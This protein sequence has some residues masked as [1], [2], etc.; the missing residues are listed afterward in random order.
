MASKKKELKY[1]KEKAKRWGSTDYLL[2]KFDD[3]ASVQEMTRKCKA[4]KAAKEYVKQLSTPKDNL[5]VGTV[6]RT[7]F[8][9]PYAEQ[10]T[11]LVVARVDFGLNG[12]GEQKDYFDALSRLVAGG[13]FKVFDAFVD[14]ID[15]VASVLCTVDTSRLAPATG[16]EVRRGAGCKSEKP[17]KSAKSAKPAKP[18]PRKGKANA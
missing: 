1:D 14:A 5:A 4:A 17:A 7:V 10:K 9:G 11:N 6:F 3:I 15:D 8:Q 12:S 16:A 13:A 2:A 18:A